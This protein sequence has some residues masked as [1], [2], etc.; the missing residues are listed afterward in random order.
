MGV[1]CIF[2]IGVSF[3]T[4]NF[5]FIPLFVLFGPFSGYFPVP[6]RIC[7]ENKFRNCQN[8]SLDLLNN[9]HFLNKLL[10]FYTK[11]CFVI[12]IKGANVYCSC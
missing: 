11:W 5:P 8:K 3:S 6:Y 12:L 9:S 1:N 10:S 7:T 4:F 2:V